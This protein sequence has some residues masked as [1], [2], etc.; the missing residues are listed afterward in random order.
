MGPAPA[1]LRATS[2]GAEPYEAFEVSGEEAAAPVAVVKPTPEARPAVERVKVEVPRPSPVAKPVAAE[3]PAPVAKAAVVPPPRFALQLL[4]AGRCLLLVELPT[5]ERFQT[6]DPA[7]MLLKDMLRAAGLPAHPKVA[8]HAKK[9][10]K[11]SGHTRGRNL[12]VS[13]F[14]VTR[15]PEDAPSTPE[16]AP[17]VFCSTFRELPGA[18]GIASIGARIQKLRLTQKKYIKYQDTHADE[19]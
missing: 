14:G 18:T 9:V 15:T 5:G 10:H 12:N 8:A 1:H 19:M 3:T 4:R 7:Y 2:C 16:D 11:I 17:V 6:R 13:W